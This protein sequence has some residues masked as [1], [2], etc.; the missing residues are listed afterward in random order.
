MNPK[1]NFILPYNL[2]NVIIKFF[3]YMLNNKNIVCRYIINF[4]SL[5]VNILYSNKT[6]KKQMPQTYEY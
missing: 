6:I 4:L 3:N 2:Y 1:V 5:R